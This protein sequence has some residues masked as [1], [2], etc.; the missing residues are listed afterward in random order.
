[1]KTIQN[2]TQHQFTERTIVLG[3][4]VINTGAVI[5]VFA[6]FVLPFL[7]MISRCS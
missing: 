1:M 5:A 2:L 4:N 3:N 6:L 7:L